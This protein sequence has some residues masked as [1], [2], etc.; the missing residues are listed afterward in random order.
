MACLGGDRLAEKFP[1]K[2]EIHGKSV[3]TSAFLREWI[4]LVR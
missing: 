2:L 4:F 3:T 1:W